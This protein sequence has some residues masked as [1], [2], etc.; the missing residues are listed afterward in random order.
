MGWYVCDSGGLVEVGKRVKNSEIEVPVTSLLDIRPFSWCLCG[1]GV[2]VLEG[3][4]MKSVILV[5]NG[6]G[7]WFEI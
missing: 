2:G 6:D 3:L 7:I 4:K 5:I 1:G